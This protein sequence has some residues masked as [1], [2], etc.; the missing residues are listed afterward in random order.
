MTHNTLTRLIVGDT[1]AESRDQHLPRAAAIAVMFA[2]ALVGLSAVIV[3]VAAV[4]ILI[5]AGTAHAD[6]GNGIYSG[7][8]GDDDDAAFWYDV[9]PFGLGGPIGEVGSL[10]RSICEKLEDGVDPG[11][12]GRVIRDALAGNGATSEQQ[13]AK[14]P[15]AGAIIRA[16]E[17]HYCP[18][19]PTY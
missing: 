10:G 8:K 7:P 16:A 6:P 9:T 12:T 19:Q 15:A 18:S 13:D 5:D 1:I 3:A 4:A 17:W 11:M 14:G 2:A